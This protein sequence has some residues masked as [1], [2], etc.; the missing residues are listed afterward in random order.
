MPLTI[1]A[2]LGPYEIL[3]PLGAG[4][5]G[6]VYRARDSRLGRD[7][8][9]KVLPEHHAASPEVRARF[10]REARAVSSLNHPNICSLFD[11]GSQ[12]GTDYLVMEMLEGETLAHRLE[13]GA[14]PAAELLRIGMQISDALDKAHRAGLVHRDLKPGN[15]MLTKTGAKLLDFGLARAVS[16]P[17]GAGSATSLPTM[18]RPL[19]AEGSLVGTFQYMSPEQLEGKEA[20]ARSDLWALGLTLYEMATGR[21]AFE[22]ASTASLIGSIM[23]DQPRPMSE[24]QPLAPPALDRVVRQ[25]LAKDPDERIQSAHDVMLQLQW[26]AE[27]GSQAG[28]PAPVAARRRGREALAWTVA[29]VAALAAL[30]LGA[31]L[32][33]R[34]PAAPRVT[35]HVIGLPREATNMGWPRLSPDGRMLA[36]VAADSSGTPR[37]WIRRLDMLEAHPLAGTEDAG[38]PY[39]SPDSKYL[40]YAAGDKLRKIAVEGG[41]SITIGDTPHGYDGTWGAKDVILFDGADADSIRG[42]SATG[43]VLKPM[44]RLDRSKGERSHAW[45]SFL[46]DGRHFLFVTNPNIQAQSMIKLGTL[47]SF[48]AK[49]LGKTDGRVEY[50]APGYLV[51]MIEGTLMAQRFDPGSLSTRGEPF[52]LVENVSIGAGSGNFTTSAD[53]TL[54]Y[55][56]EQ[57]TVKSQLLWFGRDG[58]PLGDAGPPG[59][60]RDLALSSDETRL[61]I[62]V[63]DARTNK[64]DIWIRDLARGT[65]SRLTFETGDEIYPTWAPDGKRLAF[66]SDQSGAGMYTYIRDASGVGATDSLPRSEGSE[67]P[68]DWSRDG[69]TLVTE[70]LV[71]STSWDLWAYDL[72]G[73]RKRTAVV[74]SAFPDRRARLSPDG[75]WLAYNS[76]ESGRQEVYVIGF[77]GG[78]GKW[79]V[80]IN[81]GQNPCWR[82]DGQEI[83]YRA[84]DL[85]IMAVP[86][87]TSPTFEAG[88]PKALFRSPIV[89]D[90]YSGYRWTARADGQRFLLNVPLGNTTGA[91]FVVVTGWASELQ[92]R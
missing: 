15:V 42:I 74:Q 5:M 27:G 91:E 3:A 16:A 25:C 36:F 50:A 71:G 21:R 20:D 61:A 67:R 63:V 90:G 13:R 62:S 26:V 78:G 58:R 75:R 38:R 31:V 30:T 10:E 60:Y 8:A 88:E 14:L 77:P 11:V 17:G 80:S 41:P 47:G 65:T 45:P 81:G 83:F 87:K 66:A 55:R 43:G 49:T 79:Q 2:H 37:I 46:P 34:R 53:G 92:K 19:T 70:Y 12:D 35:R 57:A 24:L 76:P 22:G 84:P 56:V 73:D 51:F 9:I 86:V 28:V 52:P 68:R 29:G 48:E 72:A 32:V 85:A 82:A 54:A 40:A 39:W 44:T 33:L 64:E 89:E 18:T 6:E 1:G 4:G 59:A 23:R 69:R 7:V